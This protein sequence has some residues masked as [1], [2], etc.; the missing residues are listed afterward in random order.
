MLGSSYTRFKAGLAMR[1]GRDRSRSPRNKDAWPLNAVEASDSD[2]INS[3]GFRLENVEKDNKARRL[4][5]CETDDDLE[6]QASVNLND[7]EMGVSAK[8]VASAVS[9]PLPKAA[10]TIKTD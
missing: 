4:C 7:L 5:E 8:A 9:A 1:A 3:D 6:Y 2:S 10:P